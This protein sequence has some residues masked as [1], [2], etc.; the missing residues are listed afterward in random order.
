MPLPMRQQT[1]EMTFYPRRRH[2]K[3]K[4]A[5]QWRS[6]STEIFTDYEAASSGFEAEL[7]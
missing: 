3:S 5:R 6:D 2:M 4:Q 1:E 7:K